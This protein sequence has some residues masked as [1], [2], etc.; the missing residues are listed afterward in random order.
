MDHQIFSP[1]RKTV[2][3]AGALDARTYGIVRAATVG[4]TDQGLEPAANAPYTA[5][6]TSGAKR[7]PHT[8]KTH[9]PSE[10]AVRGGPAEC[11]S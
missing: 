11:G 3:R 1:G 4:F 2:D 9:E 7:N 8:D 5:V 10:R 6:E